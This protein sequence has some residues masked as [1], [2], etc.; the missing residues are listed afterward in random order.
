M[1]VE[2][3]SDVMCPFCYIGKRRFEKVLDS[4]PHKDQIT[5]EWKSFLLN[6]KLET[7]PGKSI[8]QYLAESKGISIEEARSLNDHVNTM[9]AEEGLDYNL[10][11]AVLANSFMA[12]R[13]THYAKSKGKQ[14]ELEERLFQAYFSEGKN[15]DDINTLIDIGDS[16]GLDKVELREVLKSNKFE[17]DVHQ[18][19]YEGQQV[20]LKGVPF[21]V[22]NNQYGIS[23][24]Q[25]KELFEQTLNQAFDEWKA[26]KKK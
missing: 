22:Y 12:H 7:Q 21:F 20:G 2:I 6:P 14:I 16:I 26:S 9:A 8:N 4:F 3:W 18:D 11:K 24:A 15:I 23:G 13:M 17:E 1:K 5:V 19:I 10:D 25:P